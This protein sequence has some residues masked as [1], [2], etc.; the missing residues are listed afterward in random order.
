MPVA[1]IYCF[2]HVGL[3][4]Y[5]VSWFECEFRPQAWFLFTMNYK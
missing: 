3:L 1:L 5:T 2:K 4:A